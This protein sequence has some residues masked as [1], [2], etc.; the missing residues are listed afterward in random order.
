MSLCISSLLFYFIQA[1]RVNVRDE[2]LNVLTIGELYAIIGLPVFDPEN[3]KVILEV[4]NIYKHP[5]QLTSPLKKHQLTSE[6]Q[7]LRD[8]HSAAPWRFAFDLAYEFGGHITPAGTFLHLKLGLLLSLVIAKHQSSNKNVINVLVRGV[9]NSLISRLMKYACAFAHHVEHKSD[10]CLTANT[11][12]ESRDSDLTFING[13]SILL[14][15]RGICFIDNLASLKKAEILNLEKV[16]SKKYLNVDVPIQSKST[17]K[18][19]SH[20]PITAHVWSYISVPITSNENPKIDSKNTSTNTFARAFDICFEVDIED[21]S[22]ANHMITQF[23]SLRALDIKPNLLLGV[24]DYEQLLNISSTIE[25][26]LSSEAEQ[27]I[28]G[29][30]LATRRARSHE[31][32][33]IPPTALSVLTEL[34]VA[35]CKLNLRSVATE[36]D[37]VMVIWLYQD[38]SLFGSSVGVNLK[39]F[40]HMQDDNLD[41]YIGVEREMSMKMFHEQ[42]KQFIYA[43]APD[44][45][46]FSQ[47]YHEE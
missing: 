42:L 28:R 35:Y 6:M 15:H 30:F 11:T 14:A 44:L 23:I 9:D 21:D 4:N 7:Y 47:F 40:A 29:Y 43:N 13:G 33:T 39:S 22:Y 12:I 1:I 37:A 17:Q 45:E 8:A 32:I 31:Q 5:C 38:S 20:I 3:S 10:H 24:K 41:R 18:Q 16:L 34:T 19:I 2:F 25:A 46:K 27:L 26:K 36:C